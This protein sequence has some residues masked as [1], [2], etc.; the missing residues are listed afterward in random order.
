[1]TNIEAVT[2]ICDDV[3]RDVPFIKRHDTV[4]RSTTSA[5]F[6]INNGGKYPRARYQPRAEAA[7]GSFAVVLK[8]TIIEDDYAEVFFKMSYHGYFYQTDFITKKIESFDITH[9]NAMM[10]AVLHSIVTHFEN[11]YVNQL[12][13]MF[14]FEWGWSYNGDYWHNV[15]YMF[16]YDIVPTFE[17]IL[18]AMYYESRQK[19]VSMMNMMLET[20]LK[21][22]RGDISA[23]ILNIKNK[24]IEKQPVLEL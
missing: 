2:L 14:L 21:K 8:N 22:N 9:F 19:T 6:W 17:K 1:M 23:V 12:K 3:V 20:A 13:K 18:I 10:G 5:Y 16:D 15:E 24:L 11:A 7:S 4:R